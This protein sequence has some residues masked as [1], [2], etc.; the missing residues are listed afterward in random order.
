MIKP[1]WNDTPAERAAFNA[2]AFHSQDVEDVIDLI[3]QGYTSIQTDT[4]MSAS[5]L[6]YIRD[7][8]QRRYGIDVNLD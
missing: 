7:E 2:F 3:G 8:V 6:Q 1:P 4:D 5:D